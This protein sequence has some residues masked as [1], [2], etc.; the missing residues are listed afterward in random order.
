MP[1]TLQVTDSEGTIRQ[2]ELSAGEV[3]QVGPDEQVALA[4]VPMARVHA[5]VTDTDLVAL[6]VNGETMFLGGLSGHLESETGVSLAFGDGQTV[7]SLGDLL[8]WLDAGASQSGAGDLVRAGGMADLV[9]GESDV[10][11]VMYLDMG[12]LAVAP[13]GGTTG[14]LSLDDVLHAPPELSLGEALSA[15]ELSGPWADA[16]FA[17]GGAIGGSLLGGDD[18]GDIILPHVDGLA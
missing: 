11:D 4:D 8:A 17:L 6:T 9:A 16:E 3:L 18:V 12:A 15:S 14:A 1:V 10:G 2:V 13:S 7:E 5:Q